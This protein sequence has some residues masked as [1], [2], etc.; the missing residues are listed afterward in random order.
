MSFLYDKGKYSHSVNKRYPKTNQNNNNIIN[1]NNI[2][3]NKNYNKNIIKI[4]KKKKIYVF[5]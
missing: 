4:I 2:A 3:K 1:K 5:N